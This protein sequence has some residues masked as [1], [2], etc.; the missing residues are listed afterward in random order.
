VIGSFITCA[1]RKEKKE[2][3]QKGGSLTSWRRNLIHLEN[4]C[5]GVQGWST[6]GCSPGSQAKP[7]KL[8]ERIEI[9]RAL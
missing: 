5:V 2:F 9:M 3:L 6:G 8:D 1:N 4:M 7:V